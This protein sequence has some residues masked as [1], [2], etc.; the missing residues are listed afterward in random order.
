[1]EGIPWTKAW[2][3]MFFVSIVLGE[4]LILA[5]R[6]TTTAASRETGQDESPAWAISIT[7]HRILIVFP[8]T[9]LLM[10]LFYVIIIRWPVVGV[11][12]CLS[13]MFFTGVWL[14]LHSFYVTSVVSKGRVLEALVI[15]VLVLPGLA[16]SFGGW[17]TFLDAVSTMSEAVPFLLDSD[18]KVRIVAFYMGFILFIGIVWPLSRV[19]SSILGRTKLKE[20]LRV[21]SPDE[22]IAAGVCTETLAVSL[23][24]YGFTYD[25]AGTVNPEWASVF[26]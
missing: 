2:A 11:L 4:A 8:T 3:L 25:S 18:A 10:L 21:A 24:Y 20:L 22:R 23:L 16:L 1:M 12:I 13:F 26:G 9:W 14:L 17:F 19:V 5:A 15:I 6:R 7:P